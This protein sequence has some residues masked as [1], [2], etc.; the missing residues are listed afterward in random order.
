MS[1]HIGRNPNSPDGGYS[2][3]EMKRGDIY[4]HVDITCPHCDKLQPLSM[5]TYPGASCCRCGRPTQ[6]LSTEEVKAD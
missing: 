2:G 6:A 3:E 1:I 4:L 5:T